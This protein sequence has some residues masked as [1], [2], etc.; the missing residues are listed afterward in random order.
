MKIILFGKNGQLGSDFR[1][2][3]PI[4]G[5]V[6][7]LARND[8]DVSDFDAVQKTLEELK[9]GL[10]INTSAYTEVDRAEKEPELAMKINAVAPGVMAEVARNICAIFIHYSTD[11]VF[12]GKRDQPYTENDPVN[13]L[14]VYGK[15][16]WAGEENIKQAGDAYLILRTSWVYSLRGESFVNKV[17]RWAHKNETLRI[18]SDQISNPTWARALAEVTSL[19]IANHKADLL[20]IIRER[21][22]I[23]HLAG[24]GYTSRYE[25]AKQIIANDPNRTEQVVRNIEPALSEDFPTPAV[26]PLFSALNCTHFEKTFGLQLPGWSSTL[27][28]AMTG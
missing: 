22:G 26:R 28:R 7:P 13:P 3:L 11:Y 17:L 4:L 1:E 18:V 5:E 16:K 20:E 9:P 24:S 21:H 8:V 12:D 14:N 6:I 23:Y 15:S 25:W 27:E 10:I 19:M 2:I